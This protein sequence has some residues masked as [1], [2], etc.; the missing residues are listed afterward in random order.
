MKLR[1]FLKV[2]SI[3]HKGIRGRATIIAGGHAKMG[4]QL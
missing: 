3:A 1:R 2:E 4:L